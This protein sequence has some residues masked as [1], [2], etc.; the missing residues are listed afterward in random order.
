MMDRAV[1]S[2]SEIL[3]IYPDFSVDKFISKISYRDPNEITRLKEG[4][5]RVGLPS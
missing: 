1:S 2:T 5:L 3:R 4:L